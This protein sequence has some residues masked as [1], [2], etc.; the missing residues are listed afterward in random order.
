MC[1]KALQLIMISDDN[2]YVLQLLIVVKMHDTSIIDEQ[3][4]LIDS[5]QRIKVHFI[6]AT[7]I[8]Q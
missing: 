5:T 2:H 7:L 4:P 1:L 8:A 3:A 6:V